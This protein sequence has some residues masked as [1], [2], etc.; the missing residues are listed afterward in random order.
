MDNKSNIDS[1]ELRYDRELINDSFNLLKEIR[2]DFY[3]VDD[4]LYKSVTSIVNTKGFYLIDNGD[5]NIDMR[6]PEKLV[7]QCRELIETII[8]KL[9]SMVQAIEEYDSDSSSEYQYMVTDPVLY[10]PAPVPKTG[11]VSSDPVLYGPAPVPKTGGVSS[12]PVLYGPAPVPKTGGV[13]SDPVLYG[14]APVPKTEVNPVDPV[15]Y[16]PVPVPATTTVVI[17]NNNP[18]PVPTTTTVVINNN[19]PVPVPTTTTVVINNN[20]PVPVPATTTVVINKNDSVPSPEP[21]SSHITNYESIPNTSVDTKT[22]K[23]FLGPLVGASTSGI[24]AAIALGIKRKID[25]EKEE[26][27][28]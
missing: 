22:L 15:L 6:L 7:E 13:S 11:G 27:E 10:G 28:N 12:D 19:D 26:E 18:V 2:N 20:D 8:K 3:E 17:N 4:L 14:P 21:T 24:A 16:G 1:S 5:F 23:D 9:V 25:K